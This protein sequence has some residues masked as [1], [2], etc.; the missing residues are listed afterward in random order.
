[1]IR[2]PIDKKRGLLKETDSRTI[3]RPIPPLEGFGEPRPS[4][5]EETRPCPE[6]VRLGFRSFDR[7]WIIP[8]SRVIDR[9]RRE[10]WRAHSEMQLYMTEPRSHPVTG[11]PALT[12]TAEL[13]DVDHYHGRGGR[14]IPLYRKR[15]GTEPNVTPRLVSYLNGRL[16]TTVTAEHLFA[17]VAAIG[18]HSSFSIRFANELNG[19]GVRV[20]LTAV[21]S[22]FHEACGIGDR[23]L[24]LHAY[25][26]RCVDPTNGRPAHLPDSHRPQ[27]TGE[28]PTEPESPP[29]RIA[30]D[31]ETQTVLIGPG[32]IHPVPPAVWAYEVSGMR[33]VRKWFR[34][35]TNKPSGRHPTELDYIRPSYWT[36]ETIDELLDLLQVLGMLV[37]LEPDQHQLLER[38]CGGRLITVDELLTAS[39]LPVPLDAQQAAQDQERQATLF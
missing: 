36:I 25:A 30:Y 11:G 4:L 27:V 31:P 24:W 22:L 2:A 38:V 5:Y 39:V 28:I 3:D 12:F 7:Q 9:P 20:P 13:P 19:S 35:R 33:V 16:N 6:P 17:Y 37:D 14:V 10:L 15:S 23:V 21:T 8:D 29:D 34:S 32:R 26:R 1:L 18:S